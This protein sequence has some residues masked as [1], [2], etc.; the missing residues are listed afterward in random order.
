MNSLRCTDMTLHRWDVS[1]Q[2]ALR[3]QERVNKR[4]LLQNTLERIGTVAG[5]D[6]SFGDREAVAA[7]GVFD[8]ESLDVVEES[9]ATSPF[10]FPYI[11]GLLTFRE[12]P[13]I[14]QA[15]RHLTQQPD[16]I[17]FD[18]QGI[19]HPRGAGIATHLGVLLN[20]A[21]IGCAKSRLVG[22][23]VMPNE[24]KGSM[25]PLMFRNETV[26]AVVRTRHHVKPVYVSPGHLIDL[27]SAIDIVL[28]CCRRFRLPEPI[29]WAHK[30]AQTKR[31]SE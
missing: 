17:I 3:I 27:K 6:V 28:H 30:R 7:I 15:F 10:S 26:G 5:V 23:F 29:R 25:K 20:R 16:V 24:T 18:G 13:V 4:V 19:A 2:E 14:I 1:P 21:T 11:P 31:N 12:G 8:Y 22:E 9:I